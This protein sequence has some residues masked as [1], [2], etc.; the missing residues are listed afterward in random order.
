VEC[1]AEDEGYDNAECGMQNEELGDEGYGKNNKQEE[2]F[3]ST[4]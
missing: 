1:G 4:F 2:S 3:G